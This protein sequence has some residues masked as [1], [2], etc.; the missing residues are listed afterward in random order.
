[1]NFYR[2]NSRGVCVWLEWE[3]DVGRR[4]VMHLWGGMDSHD[5]I[6]QKDCENVILKVFKCKLFFFFAC[7]N[8]KVP[9]YFHT[10]R[11][12]FVWCD[13]T[14]FGI[15]HIII[16]EAA[17]KCNSCDV[18]YKNYQIVCLQL[19]I[20]CWKAFSL[21]WWSYIYMFVRWGLIM[22]ITLRI[23]FRRLWFY[24]QAAGEASPC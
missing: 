5:I 8:N 15:T 2:E 16:K 18:I 19:Y 12:F 10:F 17:M 21:P 7:V 9:S 20:F 11:I 13:W 22:T 24:P 4:V 23:Y 6:W 3:G 14:G 1:M